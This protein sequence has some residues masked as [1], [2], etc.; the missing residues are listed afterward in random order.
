MPKRPG[1]SGTYQY[2]R[3][4]S[5]RAPAR[6]Y[7]RRR[8]LPV[9][10]G[11]IA[12]V[13]KAVMM[14][15]CET[16]MSSQYTG[17]QQKLFHNKAYYAGNL[18][19]TTQGVTDPAGLTAATQNRIGDEVLAK[20][21]SIKFSI[22]NGAK[23]PNVSFRVIVFRYNTLEQPI[24]DTYFWCGT[25]GAG[26]N[27]TRLLDKPNTERVKIIKTFFMNPTMEA[28]YSATLDNQ[29][30]K[31]RTM[32]CYVPLGDRKVKYNG[33]NLTTTR[34][35][36][37]GFMVVAYDAFITLETEQIAQFQWQ[38]TFYYKDP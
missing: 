2:R 9:G 3:V 19:A 22:E 12:R 23:N 14:K 30:I 6:P 1:E 36:D 10:R 4:R 21:L 7:R 16:K 31:T 32:S 18:L 33:D 8:R 24:T 35:T 15:A 25:D 29:R 27:M 28:N 5:R 20:G 13:C 26:G 11:R 17:T 34:Y 38:S 37:I